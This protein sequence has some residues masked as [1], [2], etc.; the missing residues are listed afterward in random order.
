MVRQKARRE[1]KADG[2]ILTSQ[3]SVACD[4][5]RERIEM[6][7]TSGLEPGALATT[8]DIVIA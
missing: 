1:A 5:Q 6:K 7:L 4:S 8:M 2:R 3:F